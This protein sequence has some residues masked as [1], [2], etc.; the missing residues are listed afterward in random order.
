MKKALRN[1]AVYGSLLAAAAIGITSGVKYCNEYQSYS[2][3]IQGTMIDERRTPKGGYFIKIKTPDGEVYETGNS[4]DFYIL[5]KLFGKNLDVPVDF[6]LAWTPLTREG[7]VV[8]KADDRMYYGKNDPNNTG[9]TGQAIAMAS[10]KGIPVI[11]MVDPNWRDQLIEVLKKGNKK[12]KPKIDKKDDFLVAADRIQKELESVPKPE[13]PEAQQTG[14]MVFK[15]DHYILTL[16]PD[17]KVFFKNGTEVT[18]EII[19]NKVQIA[20]EYKQ[21]ILRTS[22][23]NNS[24]YFVLSDDRILGSGKTNYGKESIIDQEIKDKV[25]DKATLYKKE[26]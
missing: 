17:G 1:L 10:M 26:C 8:S 21:G 4:E 15:I 3:R 6:V 16:N 19:K 9:G 12:A 24:N 5:K 20:K 25:L 18:D 2:K 11:N 13:A 14:P 23:W 22:N 7:K